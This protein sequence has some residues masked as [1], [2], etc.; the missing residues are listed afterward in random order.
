MS[1]LHHFLRRTGRRIALA[2]AAAAIATGVGGCEASQKS[3]ATPNDAVSSMI[4]AVRTDDTASLK[5]IFGPDGKAILS[6]GDAVADRHQREVFVTAVD[7]G[8][9]LVD[10]QDGRKELV[11]GHEQWPFPIPLARDGS[12]WRFDTAAGEQEI[13]ARRIGRDELAAIGFCNTYVHAQREYASQG[14]DGAPAGAFAQRLRSTPGRQDGLFWPVPTGQ[15]PSPLG[16]LAAAASM[17][18]YEA[19]ARSAPQP[20]RGYFFRVLTAQGPAAPG[21]ARSY[22]VG[23]RMTG[24]FALVAYPATYRDSGVMTFIVDQQGVVYQ[25]DLGPRTV[26]VASSMTAFDPGPDWAPVNSN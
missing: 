7:Q 20:F 3:F 21:G 18:G 10:G 6:S 2:V 25:R 19:S 13:L 8:W 17:E 12:G 5:A 1:T 11:I 14:R 26:E 16:E 15:T 9:S 22:V 23:G 4:A 24:G